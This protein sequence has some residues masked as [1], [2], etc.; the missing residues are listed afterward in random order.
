VTTSGRAVFFTA[1]MMTAGVIFWYFS[2][3]R[4][5]AEMGFLLGVLMMVNM[6]VGVIV[7]PAVINILKPKFIYRPPLA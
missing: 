2:P 1:T 5:Q 4:F 3:L 7:L 6:L